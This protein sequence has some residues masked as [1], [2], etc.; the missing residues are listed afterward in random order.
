MKKFF[1]AKLNFLNVHKKN[2]LVL[3]L[4][5]GNIETGTIIYILM[6]QYAYT[7]NYPTCYHLYPSNKILTILMP[8]T[9]ISYSIT[10]TKCGI[11]Q[12]SK[13]ICRVLVYNHH[14]TRH[15]FMRGVRNDVHKKIN[16]YLSLI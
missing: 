1:H 4:Y 6:H 10:I 14:T 16:G 9:Y 11:K 8:S 3:Y 15:I 12:I 5:A 13:R 2:P 7:L